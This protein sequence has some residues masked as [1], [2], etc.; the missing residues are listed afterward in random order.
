MFVG[1][2]VLGGTE[3]KIIEAIRMYGYREKERKAIGCVCWQVA[4]GG[5]CCVI[6]TSQ[7]KYHREGGTSGNIQM[8]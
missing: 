8:R 2:S 5:R 7:G 1:I 3:N 6:Y 4:E